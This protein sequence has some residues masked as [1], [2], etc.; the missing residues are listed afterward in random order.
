MKKKIIYAIIELI[1]GIVG[2]WLLLNSVQSINGDPAMLSSTKFAASVLSFA[3]VVLVIGS[4]IGVFRHGVE[5]VRYY[6]WSAFGNRLKIGYVAK[7]GY[8]NPAFN[9]EV[10]NHIRTMR[11]MV[12]TEQGTRKLAED[13]LKRMAHMVEVPFAVPEEEH[14]SEEQKTEEFKDDVMVKTELESKKNG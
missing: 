4:I 10:D 13:W 9:D 6:K 1:I 3:Y 2:C 7:F 12:K 5:I 11:V 14:L 8:S